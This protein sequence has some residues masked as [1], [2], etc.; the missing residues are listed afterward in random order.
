MI[1]SNAKFKTSVVNKEGL[2]KDGVPEFCFV[3][4]SNV[5]KSSL[6]NSLVNQKKLVKTSST[7]GHTKMINY[8]DINDASFRFVDLPGYGFAR[9]GKSHQDIWASLMELYLSNNPQIKMI[10]L[11]VDIRHTPTE[12]DKQMLKYVFYN[13]LPVTVIA[14]KC[15]KVPKSKIINYISNIASNLALGRDNVIAYSSET[16]YNKDKIFNVI[17]NCLK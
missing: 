8:F 15:D 12:H 5:G 13:H 11:L 6:I 4:R 17:E 1:I 7:P 9:T 3:G 14:T 10:F 2:L 16:A